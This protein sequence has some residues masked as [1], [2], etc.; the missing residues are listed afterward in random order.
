[1]SPSLTCTIA[2][3]AAAF[4]AVFAAAAATA[5]AAFAANIGASSA[6]VLRQLVLTIHGH[7]GS[8]LVD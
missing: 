8:A 2:A 3:A 4:A 1:M 5:N 6:S 7:K